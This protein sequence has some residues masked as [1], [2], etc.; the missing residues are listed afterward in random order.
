MLCNSRHL[1]NNEAFVAMN[2]YNYISVYKDL[3]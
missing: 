1:E 3:C 2:G